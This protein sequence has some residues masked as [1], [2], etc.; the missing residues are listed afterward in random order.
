[1]VKWN[2]SKSRQSTHKLFQPSEI[3][4]ILLKNRGIVNVEETN[5][6]LHPS[7]QS[8]NASS[9]GLDQNHLD[10]AIARIQKAIRSKESIVVYTDYDADGV[11]GGAILWETLYSLGARVM[12][13]IPSRK[14]EGYGL[15]TI[16]I[17]A[18][19]KDYHPDLL[20]TV[21]H[22]ITAAKHVAYAKEKG[23]ETII[24]DHHVKPRI[25][26]KAYCIV[27]TSLLTATGITWF[28]SNYLL[29][30]IQ[31]TKFVT[32]LENNLDLACIG[33]VADLI[34]LV[35]P[36]RVIVTFGLQSLN[37]T[38]RIGLNA[39]IQDSNLQKGALDTFHV[40]HVL[41]PRINA[42]GR[43]THAIDA[44]RL[45]CTT[46]ESRAKTLAQKL[47]VTNR[48]RQS[49]TGS[50]T[51]LAFEMAEKRLSKLI[52]IEHKDFTEGVIGLIAG[53]LSERYYR[54]AVVLSIGEKYSKASARSISGFNIVEL[55]R[56][57][58][59]LL[60]DM[61]GHPMA[62]GFTVATEHITTLR[63]R[64]KNLVEEKLSDDLM[65][66]SVTADLELQLCEI[67]RPVYN[68]IQ[69]MAPFGAGNREPIFVS[70]GVEI[71]GVTCVGREKNHLKCSISQT[72]QD[73][74]RNNF[75]AIGFG[76]GDRREEFKT[77]QLFDIAYQITDNSWN[78]VSRLQLKLLDVKISKTRPI[79]SSR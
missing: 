37:R 33:T 5:E 38:R 26:P 58:S 52:F 69:K 3:L 21:D 25:L 32:Q 63:E 45:L 59:D 7:L 19:I 35:G 64:L 62:A 74:F 22:G 73:K 20:I 1:M 17:D 78:G 9:V 50:E 42:M 39:L 43:L 28:F 31:K 36:N 4:D 23:I 68:E 65:V 53:K 41:A 27:H 11:C 54:P 10:K 70:R 2:I 29:S 16:G 75:E 71:T 49:L 72:D 48:D 44:L 47:G 24:I 66:R 57:V 77:G 60:I 13:Y 8:I 34:P 56:E 15:S 51:I 55:F 40:S 79:H 14:T 46:D 67:S 61:G 30:E 18:I 12:P 76:M 6:Y